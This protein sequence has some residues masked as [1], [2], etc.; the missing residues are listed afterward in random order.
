MADI[1]SF[2]QTVKLPV[3]PE[4]AHALIRTLEDD[5]ADVVMVRDIIA[6]DPALTTTLL[7]MA[8]SAMFGLSRSVTSLDNAVTVVGMAQIRAR[9][10]GICMA[11]GF[12]LPPS[13][14]RQEFW[15]YSMVCAGY[16]KWLASQT[17]LDEAQAWLTGMMLRLGEL[18]IA[19]HNPSL[20]ALVDAQPCPAGERWRRE[21][22]VLGFDEGQITALVA[23]RW[24]F[25]D[26]VVQALG[27]C[28]DATAAVRVSRLCA[29][30]HL[31]GCLADQASS[32]ATVQDGLRQAPTGVLAYLK[33]PVERLV[34][35]L[36]DPEDFSDISS[37]FA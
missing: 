7:R 12:S 19:L 13:I 17:G 27:H 1:N 25:P 34:G 14:N 37:L 30:V 10:L 6:K 26:E 23:M 29:V 24:D 18:V 9:A 33:L 2:I 8:N 11:Q 3:M 15:R 16:A 21:H 35:Q 31:A 4:V 22:L 36:P 28:T 32:L 20:I 5:E